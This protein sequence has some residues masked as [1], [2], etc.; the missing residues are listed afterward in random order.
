MRPFTVEP[1]SPDELQK[2]ITGTYTSLRWGVAIIGAALPLLLWIGGMVVLGQPL[3]D[4]MSAYYHSGMRNVFVG[5]LYAAGACL[6]LYKGFNDQE[7]VALNC[8]G[9]L[10]LCI[11]VFPTGKGPDAQFVTVHGASAVLFFF[12]IAYVC[13]FRASDTLPLMQ[14]EKKAGRYRR[15]YK[16][17]GYGLIAS[18]AVAFVLTEFFRG[19]DGGN[20]FVFFVELAGVWIFAAYWVVKSREIKQTDAERRAADREVRTESTGK[21]LPAGAAAERKPAPSGGGAR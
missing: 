12:A 8:A 7:N 15:A 18:P 10:A 13:L 14:D 9:I 6:Y 11:A 2:H 16:W 21:L 19:R 20:P 3:L 17:I 4:S 5:S 1:Q